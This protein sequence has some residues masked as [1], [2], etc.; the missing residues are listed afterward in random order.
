[1][2]G[3]EPCPICGMWLTDIRAALQKAE[4]E[5]TAAY[6][7]VIH[8]SGRLGEAEGQLASLRARVTEY[9][10]ALDAADREDPM[11]DDDGRYY[12]ASREVDRAEAALR[13]EVARG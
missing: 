5:Y 2:S 4:A 12:A 7:T 3:G 8:L 6:Q 13:A 9:L 10:A 1:M 11:D